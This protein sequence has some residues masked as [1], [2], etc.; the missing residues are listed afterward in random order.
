MSGSVIAGGIKGADRERRPGEARTPA[1]GADTV[2]WAYFER[3]WIP[4]VRRPTGGGGIYHD[5]VGDVS[6][7]IV[8]PRSRSRGRPSATRGVF[9]TRPIPAFSRSA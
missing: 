3:E 7:S 4:V 8:A 5:A 6:D 2:D 1:T 9:P